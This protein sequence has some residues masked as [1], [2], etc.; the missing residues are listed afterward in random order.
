VD[1]GTE[2][3][4]AFDARTAGGLAHNTG[5]TGA[6]A[7]DA[8]AEGADA[9]NA[10]AICGLALGHTQDAGAAVAIAE[11]ADGG[12]A[13]GF[14]PAGAVRSCGPD[15][16]RLVGAA[17]KAARLL[18]SHAGRPLLTVSPGILSFSVQ[19]GKPLT[20]HT[21]DVYSLAFCPDGKTLASGS[22]G[23]PVD[24]WTGGPV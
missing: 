5:P 3:G 10:N 6:M 19:I 1:A 13:G 22:S 15:R 16:R 11:D 8:H 9:L 14:H 18:L 4:P 7:L 20:G 12:I 24:R 17:H 21:G 23:G 2:L